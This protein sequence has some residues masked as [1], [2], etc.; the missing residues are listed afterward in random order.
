MPLT[1][2]YSIEARSS[3]AMLFINNKYLHL[4]NKIIERAKLREKLSCYTE[5]HHIIPRSLGGE[6]D[7]DNLV[8]F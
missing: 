6:N 5:K 1:S 2:I 7:L 8:E 3:T 4:Y